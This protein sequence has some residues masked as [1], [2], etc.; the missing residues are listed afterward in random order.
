MKKII[1]R[2]YIIVSMMVFMLL[3]LTIPEWLKA[4]G[5]IQMKRAIIKVDK[6]FCSGCFSDIRESL[7]FL[8]GYSG[9]RANFLRTLIAVDFTEPL[10][11]EAIIEKLNAIGYFCTLQNVEA[12]DIDNSFERLNS[13]N[14]CCW[15]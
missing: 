5:N 1:F 6:L 11:A 9:M 8:D 7:I 10:T 15:K 13:G 3:A 2:R 14:S 4:E 12:I